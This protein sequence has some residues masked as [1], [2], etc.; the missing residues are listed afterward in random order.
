MYSAYLNPVLMAL[1]KKSARAST[2]LLIMGLFAGVEDG[3]I[4]VTWNHE[5]ADPVSGE[6]TA[7]GHNNTEAK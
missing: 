7:R 4:G 5:S 3:S 2:A 6:Q 1:Q